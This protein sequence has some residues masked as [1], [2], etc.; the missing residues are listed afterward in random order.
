MD[1]ARLPIAD[2]FAQVSVESV[3]AM[4]MRR[5]GFE[6]KDKTTPN[7]QMNAMVMFVAEVLSA[8]SAV[9]LEVSV[10]TAEQIEQKTVH[11]TVEEE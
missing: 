10:I 7:I 2:P 3:S 5:S 9:S 11:C 8:F 6:A 1:L 4:C